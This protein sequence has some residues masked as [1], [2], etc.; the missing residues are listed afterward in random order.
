[1]ANGVLVANAV[2]PSVSDE[3]KFCKTAPLLPTNPEAFNKYIPGVRVNEPYVAVEGAVPVNVG[4][5][6]VAE[7]TPPK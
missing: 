6:N 1:M 3:E 2:V 4:L 5:R 7:I